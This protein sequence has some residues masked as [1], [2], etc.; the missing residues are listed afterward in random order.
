[1]R[2]CTSIAAAIALALVVDQVIASPQQQV[3][4]SEEDVDLLSETAP[5]IQS[6]QRPKREFS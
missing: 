6:T 2:V 5:Q 1:M 4:T 3:F